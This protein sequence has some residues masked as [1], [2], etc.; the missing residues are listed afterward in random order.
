MRLKSAVFAIALISICLAIPVSAQEVQPSQPPSSSGNFFSQATSYFSSFNTNLDGTFDA[1]RGT[2]WTG[3]AS[4]QGGSVNLAN[5]IGLSYRVYK[6]ISLD[7]VTR[8][9]GISGGILSQQGGLSL[10]LP[11]HD[12][13]VTGYAAGGVRLG[14]GDK[15]FAEIGVR[16]RKALTAH[17]GAQIGYGIQFA[18]G[19]G[20]QQQVL[21]AAVYFTF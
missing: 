6:N 7:S 20:Q 18:G 3:A 5:E 21:T 19:H 14:E 16:L 12:A 15:I 9:A 8:T 2:F 13:Q 17:T 4:I 11:V 1:A 10:S